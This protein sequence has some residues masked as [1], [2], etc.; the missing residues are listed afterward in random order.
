MNT[1]QTTD[2]ASILVANNER[3]MS[4]FENRDAAG[5]ARMYTSDAMVMPPRSEIVFG[6]E[7]IQRGWKGAMDAGIMRLQ[8]DTFNLEGVGSTLVEVG[9][10]TMFGENDHILDRGKYVA[11]WKQ[12]GD[13]WLIHRDIWNTSV[14]Q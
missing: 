5:M 12:Q 2:T 1:M 8:L 13:Q 14:D 7:A 3:F 4:L 10:F 11:V 6:P 9:H